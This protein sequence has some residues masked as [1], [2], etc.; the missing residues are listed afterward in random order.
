M[1]IEPSSRFPG[2]LHAFGGKRFID[3]AFRT[4]QQP[5]VYNAYSFVKSGLKW[6]RVPASFPVAENAARFVI[7]PQTLQT[8]FDPF[9]IA[10]R[11]EG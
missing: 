6:H 7:C 8:L 2:V 3:F 9:Y 4:F 5:V 11:I 1:G 10:F